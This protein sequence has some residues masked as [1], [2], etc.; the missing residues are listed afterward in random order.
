MWL[1][2][3]LLDVSLERLIA[4]HAECSAEVWSF[5]ERGRI[6]HDIALGLEHLHRRGILHR[7]LKS[8]NV[9]LNQGARGEADRLW[10]EQGRQRRARQDNDDG[11]RAVVVAVDGAR[12]PVE[13]RLLPSNRHVCVWHRAR[14]AAIARAAVDAHI[15]QGGKSDRVDWRT[16]IEQ[17]TEEDARLRPT[18]TQCA[19][20][21]L[22]MKRREL[23]IPVRRANHDLHRKCYY[24]DMFGRAEVLRYD[25]R[26]QWHCL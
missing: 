1:V 3:E 22:S 19:M 24:F 5:E 13:R 25:T 9:M 7:D 26:R 11:G 16:L 6:A 4:E 23:L 17:C 14:R 12:D 8:G 10:T 21:L 18:S 15:G 20:T 2:T